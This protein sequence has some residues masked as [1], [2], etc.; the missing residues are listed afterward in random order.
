MAFTR[1]CLRTEACSEFGV[2]TCRAIAMPAP[3][4]RILKIACWNIYVSHT[5][6]GGDIGDHHVAQQVR[7]SRSS[8]CRPF[9]RTL[10]DERLGLTNVLA[11]RRK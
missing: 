11:L 10:I 9:S 2:A 3:S 8:P 4:H 7:A 6:I 1:S 5:L